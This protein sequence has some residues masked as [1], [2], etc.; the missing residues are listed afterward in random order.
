MTALPIRGGGGPTMYETTDEPEFGEFV[1][2][3]DFVTEH[4]LDV[5]FF[6]YLG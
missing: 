5:F 2:E 4:L 6:Q 3:N 1:F